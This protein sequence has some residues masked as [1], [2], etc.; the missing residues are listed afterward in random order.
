VSISGTAKAVATTARGG[1]L[2]TF[3]DVGK[4]GGGKIMYRGGGFLRGKWGDREEAG[5]MSVHSLESYRRKPKGLLAK[6]C[7][8]HIR[9]TQVWGK[10]GGRN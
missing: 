7:G 3:G 5:S 10:G 8:A 1:Q 9:L 6:G 2:G 4:R